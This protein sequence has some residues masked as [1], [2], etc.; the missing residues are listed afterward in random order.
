MRIDADVPTAVQPSTDTDGLENSRSIFS[1]FKLYM[2]RR[3]A[4]ATLI[5]FSSRA[6]REDYTLRI[7]QRLGISVDEYRV[8][9]I[10]KI[11]VDT[12]VR[13]LFEEIMRWHGDAPCW[14]NH[15]ATVDR[16]DKT[17]EHIRIL[18]LGGLRRLTGGRWPLA[19]GLGTLFKLEALRIQPVPDGAD[20]DNARYVLY[21]CHGGYPIGVFSIYVRSSIAEQGETGATQAFMAVG[22]NFYGR[23][24]W[25][26]IR[27]VS[28]LWEGI[29]NRVTANVLNRFKQLCETRFR[30]MTAG[31]G[32]GPLQ[33][34][35]RP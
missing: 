2:L 8:L 1:D 14:P 34:Q 25:P 28:R 11:E 20:F 29:H 35:P 30:E 19:H 18:L 5:R 12:P 23:R 31:D 3:P 4:I 7:K 9:N 22:F 21:E 27:L 24:W 33:E 13:Y 10:H 6:E 32:A 26:G 16:M 15:I 17:R